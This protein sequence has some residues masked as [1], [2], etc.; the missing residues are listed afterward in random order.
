[1]I[2]EFPLYPKQ[3]LAFH[4]PAR[5]LLYGGSAGGGK[6]HLARVMAIMYCAMIPGF[7]VY[8]FRREWDDLKK[9]HMEGEHGFRA[10]LAGLVNSG[11]VEIVEKEIR[12]TNGSK[13]FLCHAQHEKDVYG[14]Q[15]AEMPFIIL[16]EATQFSEFMIRFLRSRN[17]MPGELKAKIPKEFVASFPKILYTSNPGGVSHEFFKKNFIE[18]LPKYTQHGDQIIQAPP[19]EGGYTRVFIPA[20]LDDNPSLDKQEYTNTLMGLKNPIM[21]RAYLEGDW[22]IHSGSYFNM[23]GGKHILEPFSIPQHWNK[24]IGFDWGYRSP[25]SA[26][27][28]AISSGK[29]DQ[30]LEHPVP[31]GA[32]VVYRVWE[33]KELSNEEIGKGLAL[34]S[35]GENY[36][37]AEA[38]NQIFDATRGIPI[39]DG[40][41]QGGFYLFSPADKTRVPGWQEII[42]RLLA[43][44]EPTL[45]IFRT[46]SELITAIEAAQ[47]DVKN[48]EDLDTT[49]NDHSLDALRYAVMAA[50]NSDYKA[51]EIPA[52]FGGKMLVGSLIERRR[53][54]PATRI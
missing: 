48:P 50:V 51:P 40:I 17:R 18:A 10:M 9:N 20:R 47:V 44:P 39:N 16:E 42:R 30:G 7:S 24:F 21:V 52:V 23:F 43:K 6:S 11:Q 33:D 1:M 2:V 14:Y 12:F 19:E 8:I 37:S 35:A 13:I 34:R 27:W 3:L 4:C 26:V 5:E 54:A 41:K 36:V 15:G 32:I 22:N 45:Y 28:I 49:G 31:K 38:D 25:F 29:D 46:C 53:R